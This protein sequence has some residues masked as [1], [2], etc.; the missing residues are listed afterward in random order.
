M[1]SRYTKQ[2]LPLSLLSA[3]S[4]SRWKV[5]GGK[6]WPWIGTGQ[7]H[8]WRLF[9]LCFQHPCWPANI[10][11]WDPVWWKSWLRSKSPWSPVLL[12]VDMHHPVSLNSIS[13]C[14][15]RI[16]D[17][18]LSS[19]ESEQLAPPKQKMMAR[20]CHRTT[21]CRLVSSL[22]QVLQG[23]HNMVFAGSEPLVSPRSCAEGGLCDPA[24]W[25][26]HLHCPGED[27][28]LPTLFQPNVLYRLTE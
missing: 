23:K 13:G 2:I 26:R 20:W 25:C 4:I 24:L 12:G 19:S 28:H 10:Q 5:A 17:P 6:A 1:S 27:L 9:S 11:S 14:P 3:N 8:R 7:K 22:P 18:H 16:W 15:R 21:F